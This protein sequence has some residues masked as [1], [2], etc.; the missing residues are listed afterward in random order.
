MSENKFLKYAN[1]TKVLVFTLY[2]FIAINLVLAVLS[3]FAVG[4]I[5][6]LSQGVAVSKD[7]I[8][9]SGSRLLILTGVSQFLFCLSGLIYFIWLYRS[10]SNALR[11]CPKSTKITPGWAIGWYFIPFANFVIPYNEMKELYKISR[12]PD[13]WESQKPMPEIRCWW[14]FWILSN[15][16]LAIS[17]KMAQLNE[18][19]HNM[20][21]VFILNVFGYAGQAICA[22]FL[23]FIINEIYILQLSSYKTFKN[24]KLN[25]NGNHA[26]EKK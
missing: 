4:L 20:V 2:C 26:V 8:S 3:A 10:V 21:Y 15:A 5:V 23:V 1:L 24:L 7:Y 9:E 18:A 13:N 16:L 17:S 14:L 22:F 19:A 25:H 11:F 6:D 12:N